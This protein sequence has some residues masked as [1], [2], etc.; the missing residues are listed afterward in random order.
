MYFITPKD[1]A[2]HSSIEPFYER[3]AGNLIANYFGKCC[4]CNTLHMGEM[5][6]EYDHFGLPKSR[7]D[8]I[9]FVLNMA[10]I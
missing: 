3:Y 4:S 7:E 5:H 9:L 6:L 10:T 1:Y 8:F 2:G